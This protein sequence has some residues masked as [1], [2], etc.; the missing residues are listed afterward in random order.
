MCHDTV[1]WLRGPLV[2]P[3]SHSPNLYPSSVIK[4]Y[5]FGHSRNHMCTLTLCH[6]EMKFGLLNTCNYLSHDFDRLTSNRTQSA[7]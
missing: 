6:T 1:F 5:G 2:T 4:I 3:L 7:L